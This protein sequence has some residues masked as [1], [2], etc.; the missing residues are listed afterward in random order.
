LLYPANTVRHDQN[1][2]RGWV[3]HAERAPGWKVTAPPLVRLG[4]V[5]SKSDCTRTEPVNRL[6]E[7]VIT[8]CA[9]V[10]VIVICGALVWAAVTSFITTEA[11]KSAETVIAFRM[12]KPFLLPI[13]G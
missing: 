5:G 8:F 10:G 7:P 3:C 1:R 13:Q 9:A 11:S 4:S 6:G 12:F 2:P